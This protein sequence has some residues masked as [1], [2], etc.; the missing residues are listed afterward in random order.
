VVTNAAGGLIAANGGGGG[1]SAVD[2]AGAEGTVNNQ[3][4]ISAA[5]GSPAI[6]IE[7]GTVTNGG[8]IIGGV[9]FGGTGSDLLVV[10]PGAVFISGGAGA[11][12]EAGAAT[13]ELA[14]ASS[15]GTISG[16]G[17]SFVGFDT[18]AIDAGANWELGGSNTAS[19]FTNDGALTLDPSTLTVADLIGTGTTTIDTGSRRRRRTTT[20]RPGADRMGN[21]GA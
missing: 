19:T 21:H 6:L 12:I 1:A 9:T 15:A 20:R 7:N 16:I 5:A 2:I 11:S 17:S 3:G 14:S 4:T 8:T 10:D 18:V 13:L